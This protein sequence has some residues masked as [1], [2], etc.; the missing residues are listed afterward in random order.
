MLLIQTYRA[1]ELWY[2]KQPNEGWSMYHPSS[3]L[4]IH[5]QWITAKDRCNLILCRPFAI[6]RSTKML[7]YGTLSSNASTREKKMVERQNPIHPDHDGL[8]TSSCSQRK[9]T[10]LTARSLRSER[11]EASRLFL[12]PYQITPNSYLFTFFRPSTFPKP[13]SYL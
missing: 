9:L 8:D 7:R 12:S 10:A 2:S 4:H 13:S 3:L 6:A 11:K 5:L 1:R